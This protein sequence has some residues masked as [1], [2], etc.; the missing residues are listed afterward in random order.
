MVCDQAK[1][2]LASH[3]V[4]RLSRNYFEPC[5]ALV[6]TVIRIQNLHI[7]LKTVSH[8]NTALHTVQ[9]RNTTYSTVLLHSSVTYIIPVILKQR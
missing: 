9:E 6:N 2:N 7:L 8:R 4:R 3:R 1:M 5:H